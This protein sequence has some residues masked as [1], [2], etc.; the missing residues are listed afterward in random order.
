ME[1]LIGITCLFGMMVLALV[2]IKIYSVIQ[3]SMAA[4]KSRIKQK[5]NDGVKRV[6]VCPQCRV[7]LYFD[8]RKIAEEKHAIE[9]A[10]TCSACGTDSVWATLADPPELRKFRPKNAKGFTNARPAEKTQSA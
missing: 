2:G 4:T 8:V 10:L 1:Y 6:C 3:H 5:G 9:V 7:N